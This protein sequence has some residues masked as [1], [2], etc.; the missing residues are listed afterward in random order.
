MSNKQILPEHATTRHKTAR[1]PDIQPAGTEHIT[2]RTVPHVQESALPGDRS[3]RQAT[4]RQMQQS[5]GNAFVQRALSA[6]VQR[7]DQ[8]QMPTPTTTSAPDN[9]TEQQ[10][11]TPTPTTSSAPDTT[12]EQQA[13]TP[14][15]ETQSPGAGGGTET[16][17]TQVSTGG[18]TVSTEGG[19]VRVSGGMVQVDAPVTRV[20]GVLNT[21][22]LIANTVVGSSYT[23]GVGNLQ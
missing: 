21:D 1:Q 22:T 2:A 15:P 14:T 19:I 5:H 16:T 17:P 8:A 11:Q 7:E 18:A 23:P 4:I 9:A 3:L 10:A 13:Q 12:T 6:E 20:S